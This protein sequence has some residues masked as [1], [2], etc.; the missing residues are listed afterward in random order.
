V[1]VCSDSHTCSAGVFNCLARGV[2]G[3]DVFYSA[4]TGETWYRC[5][6]TVRYELTG[7]LPKA[8]TT[9]DAFLQIAGKHGAHAT[10]NVEYGGR[11]S[12][13][14]RSTRARR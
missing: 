3:P 10:M 7:K 8:V 9:K 6:E 4:I 13:V 1:L 12:R 11:E 14:S 5:G 2:G